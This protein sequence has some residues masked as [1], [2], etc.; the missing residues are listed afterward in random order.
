MNGAKY[1]LLKIL[2]KYFEILSSKNTS[3]Q[4]RNQKVIN[5]SEWKLNR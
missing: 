1:V 3:M 4:G 2:K 5:F